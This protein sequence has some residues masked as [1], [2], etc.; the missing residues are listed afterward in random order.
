MDQ[1]LGTTNR[2]RGRRRP[3]SSFSG[4]TAWTQ[5]KRRFVHW[6]QVPDHIGGLRRSVAGKGQTFA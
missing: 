3:S 5:A 2:P 4:R 6:G 1:D